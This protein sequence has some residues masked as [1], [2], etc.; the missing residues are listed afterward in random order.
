M[1]YAKVHIFAGSYPE[2]VA[3]FDDINEWESVLSGIPTDPHR[4]TQSGNSSSSSSFIINQQLQQPM[5][6]ISSSPLASLSLTTLTHTSMA[7]FQQGGTDN[8]IIDDYIQTSKQKMKGK[9]PKSKGKSGDHSDNEE[10][11][12]AESVEYNYTENLFGRGT[13]GSAAA[14]A[15]LYASKLLNGAEPDSAQLQRLV[16]GYARV[17]SKRDFSGGVLLLGNS[18]KGFFTNKLFGVISACAAFRDAGILPIR[19]QS[20]W[21][22]A[23][24][25]RAIF[26]CDAEEPVPL[27]VVGQSSC[28]NSVA[29]PYLDLIAK[30]PLH[31]KPVAFYFVPLAKR[32]T[33]EL[34][35]LL[36]ASDPE[37]RALFCD[38]AW[39]R[40]VV[41]QVASRDGSPTPALVEER[42]L[43]YLHGARGEFPLAVGEATIT[44]QRGSVTPKAYPFMESV[45]AYPGSKS[46]VCATLDYWI[47]PKKKGEHDQ[48]QHVSKAQVQALALSRL[49]GFA[50]KCLG[51]EQK[52]VGQQSEMYFV[53]SQQTSKPGVMK[54]ITNKLYPKKHTASA[55]SLPAMD[56]DATF[57]F[58]MNPLSEE[59]VSPKL[60]SLLASSREFKIKRALIT[61]L[62][63]CVSADESESSSSSS[64]DSGSDGNGDTMGNSSSKGSASSRHSDGSENEGGSEYNP[65][66]EGGDMDDKEVGDKKSGNLKVIL[67]GNVFLNVRTLSVKSC[68]ASGRLLSIKTFV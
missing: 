59:N 30:R 36:A 50:V 16:D 11:D 12:Y 58:S 48:R 5:Q 15:S 7:Q 25:L 3:T 13:R 55:L 17:L 19:V 53:L 26:E 1:Q 67:D 9:G 27:I 34:A 61:K 32:S 21:D 31:S 37:Y 44:Q 57:T 45:Q 20:V 65:E 56:T 18:R 29:R 2:T 24:L 62:L 35:S 63:C 23:A 10:N 14:A 54:M 66:G 52:D 38:E 46:P 22:S 40:Q 42:I 6:T 28:L 68:W 49:P 64:S 41:A 47:P 39:E 51:F 43:R 4:I 33:C 8:I 60:I